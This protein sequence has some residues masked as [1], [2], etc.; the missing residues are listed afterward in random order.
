MK[1]ALLLF[2]L[3]YSEFTHWSTKKLKVDWKKSFTNYKDFIYRYFNDMNYD[4]DLYFSTTKSNKAEQNKII[5]YYNPIK[6]NFSDMNNDATESRK[7]KLLNVI[8]LCKSTN[9]QYDYILIT[10]FDLLFKKN[11]AT[12]NINLN[13][14]NVV[15]TMEESIFI[16]DNFY[17]F[18][19]EMLHKFEG[20]VKCR[21][22]ISDHDIRTDLEIALDDEINL[23][24][25][26]RKPPTELS[27]Y[28]IV[29][30]YV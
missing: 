19:F 1:V 8:D 5:R 7:F 17:L 12:S 2:G 20:V 16:D 24:L 26:E 13:K 30:N 11:F 23:I 21:D 29:R 18:P 10:R 6:Y 25:D 3:S 9:I 15:S 4:V 22:F 28:K 14:F 27:F